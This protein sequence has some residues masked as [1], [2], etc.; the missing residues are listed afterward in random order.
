[1]L[2]IYLSTM[3]IGTNLHVEYALIPYI[4]LGVW[5]RKVTLLS[6]KFMH[7]LRAHYSYKYLPTLLILHST[8]YVN[9]LVADILKAQRYAMCLVTMFTVQ[10]MFCQ[11]CTHQLVFTQKSI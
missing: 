8:A 6:K 7:D 11:A 1:M 4:T 3:I 2:S 5:L 10:I 9:P